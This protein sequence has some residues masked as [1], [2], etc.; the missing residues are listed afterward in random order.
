VQVQLRFCGDDPA[1]RDSV[2]RYQQDLK[3]WM[4]AVTRWNEARQMDPAAAGT[5]PSRPLEP[6]VTPRPCRDADMARG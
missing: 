1:E 6:R 4:A 2:A 3:D 5:R